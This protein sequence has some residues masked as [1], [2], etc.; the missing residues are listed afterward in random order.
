MRRTLE[1]ATIESAFDFAQQEVFELA[2]SMREAAENMPE[3]LNGA[4]TEAANS[5]QVAHDF[6]TQDEIPIELRDEEVAWREW[7]G[8]KIFRP[9]RRDNVV[10]FLRAYLTRLPQDNETKRL[11]KNLELA[12]NV[13][14][15]IFFP[16]MSGK[17]AA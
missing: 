2:E 17:R 11:R 4:Y 13:L 10:N 5:L 12:I 7:R 15:S 16:G 9:Q 3:Q 8:S 6:M 14:D 1:R